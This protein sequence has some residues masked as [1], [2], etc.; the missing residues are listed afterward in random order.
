MRV[1]V[2]SGARNSFAGRGMF[3]LFDLDPGVD[4]WRL[5]AAL[6]ERLRKA[7]LFFVLQVGGFG[8]K[9]NGAADQVYKILIMRLEFA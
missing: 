7:F 2:T 9:V 4:S 5:A 3:L 6:K 1:G 8:E